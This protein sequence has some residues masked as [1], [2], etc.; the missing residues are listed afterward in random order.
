[1]KK[2]KSEAVD[3]RGKA[4]SEKPA[5]SQNK[6]RDMQQKTTASGWQ[7]VGIV[8]LILLTLGLIVWTEGAALPTHI[9]AALLGC[10][11]TAIITWLLLG[12]QSKMQVKMQE[13]LSNIDLTREKKTRIYDEKIQVYQRYL[14]SL[15]EV[16]MARR[17]SDEQKILL[18][19]QIAEIAMHTPYGQVELVADGI[20]AIVKGLD[21]RKNQS[22]DEVELLRSLFD[23]VGCFKQELYAE[24]DG[25]RPN[26][27]TDERKHVEAII[28]AFREAFATSDTDGGCLPVAEVKDHEAS[29][30]DGCATA[31]LL[32]DLKVDE[33]Q[34]QRPCWQGKADGW[35]CCKVNQDGLKWVKQDFPGIV[36]VGFY[37]G[38][39]YIQANY[40]DETDFSTPMKREYGGRRSYG[41]WWRHL[42]EPYYNIKEGEFLDCFRQDAALQGYITDWCCKLIDHLERYHKVE[43][44]KEKISRWC[45]TDG[46]LFYY[47]I[48]YWDLLCCQ[49]N[50]EAYGRPFIDMQWQENKVTLS[51]GNRLDDKEKLEAVLG[52]MFDGFNEKTTRCEFE[53]DAKEEFEEK[54]KAYIDQISSVVRETPNGD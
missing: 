35:Q 11:V 17:I 40:P 1:M 41:A 23:I 12:R 9:I 10:V 19:F 46:S 21:Q 8:A 43:E 44:Q 15:R 16:V 5:D 29:A 42:D 26:E 50:S 7:I 49:F 27:N 37:E 36:D 22:Q 2:E 31:G 39:Y 45:P 25:V 14:E 18:Q 24:S 51:I 4:A 34:R 47:F 6:A 53:V 32:D 28:R 48:W 38:H 13:D 54:L 52:R 33:T 30:T 3:D 20:Q